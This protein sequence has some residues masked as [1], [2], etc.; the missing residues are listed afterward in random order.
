MAQ[1][2][3]NN[4]RNGHNCAHM[5]PG[6]IKHFHVH[7]TY[8]PKTMNFLGVDWG[9]VAE[10]GKRNFKI[11]QIIG[12]GMMIGYG[13]ANGANGVIG[14]GALNIARQSTWL[15]AED[16]QW[17]KKNLLF[18]K[19]ARRVTE[20]VITTIA[21]ASSVP[22]L[23]DEN[24]ALPGNAAALM[25]IAAYAT[26]A[27]DP[28]IQKY[29]KNKARKI[30]RKIFNEQREISQKI[31][32]IK[33]SNSTVVGMIEKP[34]P[35]GSL[36]PEF[37]KDIELRKSKID[38]LNEQ[39]MKFEKNI[40]HLYTANL[41]AGV[42]LVAR[43]GLQLAA[44][45]TKAAQGQSGWGSIA[46]GAIFMVGSTMMFLNKLGERNE[47]SNRFHERVAHQKAELLLPIN[48]FYEKIADKPTSST[49]PKAKPT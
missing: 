3:Q 38:Q 18:N 36:T 13:I 39:S 41:I 11:G 49:T 12:Q 42:M 43:G 24:E 37:L 8:K 4:N 16:T 5:D 1:K 30:T 14:T 29:Q 32:A 25:A 33:S 27:L 40:N 19:N 10:K 26:M 47:R 20:T 35:D 15:A 21:A 44:G 23:L 2:Q 45:I 34:Q 46:A 17:V 6:E 48:E 31:E 9:H 7:S 28:W 22:H